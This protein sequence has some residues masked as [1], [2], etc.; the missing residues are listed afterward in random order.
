M[1]NP[2]E[3]IN[4][5]NSQL[6]SYRMY[7]DKM[8]KLAMLVGDVELRNGVSGKYIDNYVVD[9]CREMLEIKTQIGK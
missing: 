3:Y 1:P 2:V 4:K 9:F 6:I 5:Y 8:P 7:Y